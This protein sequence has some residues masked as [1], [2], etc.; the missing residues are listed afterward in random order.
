MSDINLNDIYKLTKSTDSLY[1]KYIEECDENAYLSDKIDN[2]INF[3]KSLE[4]Q[5]EEFKTNINNYI[6]Q[7]HNK[8]LIISNYELQVNSLNNDIKYFKNTLHNL[9]T[10]HN[11]KNKDKFNR[12][13]EDINNKIKLLTK[14]NIELKQENINMYGDLIALKMTKYNLTTPEQLDELENGFNERK[15]LIIMLQ[16]KDNII[17]SLYSKIQDLE[18]QN[19]NLQ[20]KPFLDS[21]NECV[22]CI[23]KPLCINTDDFDYLNVI[24]DDEDN[25]NENNDELLSFTSIDTGYDSN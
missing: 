15:K 7:I 9:I 16:D 13:N 19:H 14:E 8:N 4:D 6:S 23:K 17:N 12:I 5:N 10:K 21:C 11:L 24:D 18:N 2:L 22:Q 1:E 25:D 3:I 20:F